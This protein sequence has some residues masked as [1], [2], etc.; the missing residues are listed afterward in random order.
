MTSETWSES[1]DPTPLL[2]CDI[3][4]YFHI[5][6][7]ATLASLNRIDHIDLFYMDMLILENMVFIIPE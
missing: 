1:C 6:F 4:K 5:T 7:I 2:N 3:G